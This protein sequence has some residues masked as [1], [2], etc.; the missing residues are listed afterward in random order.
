MLQM[1]LERLKNLVRRRASAA[2]E[3]LDIPPTIPEPIEVDSENRTASTAPHRGFMD[4]IKRFVHIPTANAQLADQDI[5]LPRTGDPQFFDRMADWIP[6]VVFDE[7]TGLFWIEGKKPG[8]YEGVGFCMELTPQTGASETMANVLAGLTRLAAPAST[9][10]QVTLLGSPCIEPIVNCALDSTITREEALEL[11]KSG[12][13]AAATVQQ[14]EAMHSMAQ[15]MAEHLYK[16]STDE[17]FR[18]FNYRF[19]DYRIVLS[20]I[21]P[22]SNPQAPKVQ[23]DVLA[24]RDQVV[25]ATGQFYLF[26]RHWGPDDLLSFAALLLNPH[27]MYQRDWPLRHYDESKE[28]RHQVLDNDNAIDIEESRVLFSSRTDQ[29]DAIAMRA[30][31]VKTYPMEMSLNGMVQLLGSPYNDR[32]QYTG[33]FVITAGF[34]FLDYD[35]EKNRVQLRAARAQQNAEGPLAR[36]MPQLLDIASDWK[37]LQ[38]A[39]DVGLGSVKMYHQVLVYARPEAIDEAEQAAKAIWRE[40]GFELQRDRFVQIQ[41]LLGALPMTFGP[42]LQRDMAMSQRMSTKTSYNAANLLP[43]LAEWKGTGPRQGKARPTPQLLLGGRRGQVMMIDIFANP[44]GNNNAC[45][46]GKSRSG[47]SFTLNM[48]I[49]R[50]LA[51]GGRAWVFDIGGSYTKM[52]KRL[53]G[54]ILTFSAESK[55]SLN[56]FSIVTDLEEDIDMIKGVVARMI[57]PT[58]TMS[59]FEMSQLDLHIRSVFLDAQLDYGS[60]DSRRPFP[61]PTIEDL[62]MSLINNCE[63]GGPN[64]LSQDPEWKAKVR[65]MSAEERR[66]ICDPRIAD[67]GRSLMP[68]TADGSYGR[69]FTGPANVNFD[70][71]FILLEMD[72]LSSKPELRA[73]VLMLLMYLI[74]QNIYMGR[75]DLPKLCLLDEAWDLMRTGATS[76]FIEGLYRKVAK[77]GGA[78]V[79]ATQGVDDYYGS[80][81]AEAALRNADWMFL[82]QQKEESIEQIAKSGKLILDESMKRELRSVRRVG[83]QYSEIFIKATDYPPTVGRLFADPYSRLLSS[84]SPSEVQALDDLQAQGMSVDEAIQHMLKQGAPA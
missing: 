51:S 20:V 50:T 14:A 61:W 73:V 58:E 5:S 10:V 36:Y 79:T 32:A 34:S 60:P 13:K 67:L 37:M 48:M 69:W 43:L 53:G 31:S 56:P 59:D 63:H 27:R 23:Q 39:Y 46:V 38:E 52:C 18:N 8:T 72:H 30:L 45:V 41:G 82:L 77:H 76:K 4:A 81:T 64:P 80:E 21:W 9:G 83:N 55:I 2:D 62:A 19:K 44:S 3:N 7:K 75:R 74:A 26:D 40:A 68:Y 84:T 12:R 16:G 47:K 11:E 78:V 54:Q 29:K 22:T 70:S 28:L 17:L 42:L 24:M 49:N 71:N 65:T 33:P 66:A 25:S 15:R 1:L 6:W 35:R 57:K